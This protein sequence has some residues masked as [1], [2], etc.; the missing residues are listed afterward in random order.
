MATEAKEI[1][2]ANTRSLKELLC[3]N[4][5]GLY[6][7]AYQRPYGWDKAKVSRLIDDTLHG[8][9]GLA[10]SPDTFT[11]LGTVITIH[12]TNFATVHP[13]V[14]SE[15]P[16][17]VLTVIDGQ[18]R[19]T[20]LLALT[21]CLHAQIRVRHWRLF[22]GSQPSVED[23][24]LTYLHDQ[25][26]QVLAPLAMSFAEVQ[27]YGDVRIYP[28]MIRAFVDQWARKRPNNIY[29]SPLAH[30]I[31][32]YATRAQEEDA[33]GTRPTDYRARV[34]DEDVSAEG[35]AD[36]VRRYADMR[37]YLNRLAAGEAGAEDME[38]LPPLAVLAADPG[39]QRATLGHEMPL[40]ASS[41]LQ[42]EP[43]TSAAELARLLILAA[44]VLNRIALT[45]VQG[46]DENYAFTIFESLNT[47]G[48]PLTAIET[49]GP[50]VVRA[51]G[52]GEYSSSPAR[53]LFDDVKSYV[54][55]FR[56]GDPR[57][58]ATRD[59]LVAFALAETGTKLSKRLA[60]QRMYLKD[61]FE[62]YVHSP[63]GRY[64]FLTSLRDTSSLVRS[65]WADAAQPLPDLPADST[66]D[67]I[68][69]CMSFLR[70][71]NH[72]VTLGLMARYYSRAVRA[73]GEARLDAARDLEAVLKAVTA[74]TVLWRGSRRTTGNIDQQHR[75]LMMGTDNRTGMPRIARSKRRAEDA[76][77]CHELP[78]VTA[79]RAELSARL[80]SAGGV[81]DRE[82][83]LSLS[84]SLPHYSISTTLT[85]FM[86]LAAYHDSVEDS[87]DPGLLRQGR[88]DANP[89]L[90]WQSWNKSEL[91]TIEHVAPQQ[92]NSPGWASELYADKELVDRL[93]NLCLAPKAVNSS[94]GI[95]PWAEKRVLYRAL[96]SRTHE[97][98]LAQ[99]EAAQE[100]GI[101]FVQS[102]EE[103]V[104]ASHHMPH[105]VAVGQRSEEWNVEFVDERTERVLGLVWDRLRPWL[106]A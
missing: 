22:R 96:G 56:A 49:F 40:A 7:P 19:L 75:E 36:L 68:R 102:T 60:D 52:L 16:S 51:E 47:T 104:N 94:L 29:D 30:L 9:A 71:M 25:T 20:T 23:E 100:R 72:S 92:M 91:M 62:R 57:Q 87:G 58:N 3:Q 17:K 55:G 82:Q 89:C 13:A 95:R 5:L 84:K 6:I 14:R 1:F 98:A 70:Q 11:F 97:E 76:G 15:T 21:A 50:R 48:E 34:R 64:E 105:L 90:N 43:A 69:L 77:M 8:L 61:E 35:E 45:V 74:F 106:E 86:L 59:L 99:L 93:G 4:G 33:S 78:S 103:L 2:D 46:K 28:R 66:T 24:A 27:Q 12:D 53:A 65:T 81:A 88:P 10:S 67:T 85:R 26:Q 31:F 37:G 44:Y 18:Q 83:W 73:T 101:T 79:L 54:E 42:E 80:A 38:A 39:L 32:D 41:Y 63:Q